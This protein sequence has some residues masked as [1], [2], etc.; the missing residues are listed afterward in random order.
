ML[1]LSRLD[2][3]GEKSDA[4]SGGDSERSKHAE[5]NS[6]KRK[7]GGRKSKR[8]D[9]GS[10]RETDSDRARRDRNSDTNNDEGTSTLA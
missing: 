8:R 9:E 5:H 6:K 7:R 4:D 3:L 10:G 2:E 1:T